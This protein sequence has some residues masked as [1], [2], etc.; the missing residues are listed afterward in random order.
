MAET[1]F[2]LV[3]DLIDIICTIDDVPVSAL[4]EIQY[5][6]TINAGRTVS[7]AID[8]SQQRTL[9][10]LGARIDLKV[11]QNDVTIKDSHNLDFT[12]IIVEASPSVEFTTFTAV[13]FVTFLQTSE[14]VDYKNNDIVGED[15]YFLAAE[16]CNYKGID[17]SRLLKGSG[18]IA[19]EEMGLAGLQT[20]RQFLDK[21]FTNM[22]QFVN[23]TEHNDVV[24][25]AWRYAI[26]RN[27]IM[28]F[29]LE[30]PLNK[31][32]YMPVMTVSENSSNLVGD[33]LVT[34]VDMTQVVNSATYQ[35]NLDSTKFAT[36]TDSDS[37][38]RFGVRSRL[39]KVNSGD[40][41]ML[42]YQA[43]TRFKEPTFDYTI[44]LKNAE[45]ITVGDY[46]KVR[47]LAYEKEETLPVVQVTHSFTDNITTQI[48]LGK[49]ELTLKEY[50]E[51]GL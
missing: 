32:Y 28:D 29:W 41:E 16:A 26:K 15:L 4:L 8:S 37:V 6:H 2:K 31:R 23:D 19:T 43:V 42:A 50:I 34:S 3:S 45:H 22:E 35:S 18:I 40:L 46:I 5:S 11:G 49:P 25:V 33:G 39:Y 47:N 44:T 48:T 27:N 20:R 13:D 1:R 10:R 21:C 51:A 36:V 30:D 24:V 14:Y 17:T 38:R 12:G 9:A 7:I